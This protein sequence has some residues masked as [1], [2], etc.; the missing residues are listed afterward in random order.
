MGPFFK[1]K[2]VYITICLI[3]VFHEASNELDGRDKSRHKDHQQ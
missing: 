1:E 3:S 2:S